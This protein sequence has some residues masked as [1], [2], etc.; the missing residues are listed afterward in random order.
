MLEQSALGVLPGQEVYGRSEAVDSHVHLHSQVNAKATL[1]SG[2]GFIQRIDVHNRHLVFGNRAGCF[3]DHR[4][5][6]KFAAAKTVSHQHHWCRA[7]KVMTATSPKRSTIAPASPG[8]PF[9]TSWPISSSRSSAP[10]RADQGLGDAQR[11]GNP[12]LLPS[13]ER[14]GVRV[15]AGY[16][17]PRGA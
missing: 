15:I 14:N 8:S 9:S 11:I 12:L 16:R 6:A 10:A 2:D 4:V 5:L 3:A 13:V 17:T 7:R 1:R